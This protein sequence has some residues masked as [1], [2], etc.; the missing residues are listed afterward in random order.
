M[1]MLETDQSLA[2]V[3][4]S[5]HVATDGF[6][7]TRQEVLLV[8]VHNLFVDTERIHLLLVTDPLCDQSKCILTIYNQC[9][10]IT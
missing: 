6:T 10:T 2:Y 4:S 3:V 7:E 1:V 8:T 5:A 9:N